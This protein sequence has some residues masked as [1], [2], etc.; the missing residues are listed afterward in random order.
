MGGSVVVLSHLLPESQFMVSILKNDTEELLVGGAFAVMTEN[1]AKI[2]PPD[3]QRR[4]SSQPTATPTRL[5]AKKTITAQFPRDCDEFAAT[6][7]KFMRQVPFSS[8]RTEQ[9]KGWAIRRFRG[10]EPHVCG[11]KCHKCICGKR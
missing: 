10:H 9:N 3:T 11:K 6:D 1:I 7:R 2:F 4:T 8:N 5:Y